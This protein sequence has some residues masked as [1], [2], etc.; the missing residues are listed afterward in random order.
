MILTYADKD[1]KILETIVN[2]ELSLCLAC[3]K[4]T[5]YQHNKITGC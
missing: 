3:N 2:I 1:P 5:Y 4:S